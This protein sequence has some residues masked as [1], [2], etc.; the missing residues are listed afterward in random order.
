MPIF[1]TSYNTSIEVTLPANR[2]GNTPDKVTTAK[3]T[4][5]PKEWIDYCESVHNEDVRRCNLDSEFIRLMPSEPTPKRWHMDQATSEEVVWGPLRGNLADAEN[6]YEKKWADVIHGL[7]G[8]YSSPTAYSHYDAT[9][10][11]QECTKLIMM[12]G[13]LCAKHTETVVNVRDVC[14]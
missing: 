10:Y 11:Q 4:M 12:S 2:P 1:D 6:E 3:K 5:E 8:L 13:M 14:T 7:L 9:Y